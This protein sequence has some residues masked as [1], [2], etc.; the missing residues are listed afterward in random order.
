MSSV[1]TLDQVADQLQLH[2]RTVRRYVRE[3]RLKARRVGKQYLV[4]SED[5]RA[6]SGITPPA[7]TR[8]IENNAV[9]DISAVAP[10]EASRV[11]NTL[12]A[13]LQTERGIRADTLYYESEGRLK[14]ILHGELSATIPL[15]DLLSTVLE[16]DR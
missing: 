10:D 11:T 14:V 5:L 9:I 4:T 2:V 1:Y 7:V 13:A 16:G 3:G 12:M 8:R 15:L 6:F